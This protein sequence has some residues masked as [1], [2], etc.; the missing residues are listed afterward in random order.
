MA[1]RRPVE[2]F[3]FRPPTT[4]A[5]LERMRGLSEA[6]DGWMNLLPGVPEE[7]V[8]PPSRNI[9]SSL[10]GTAQPPVSMC[11][12][13]PPGGARGASGGRGRDEG[14]TIGILHP[15]GR[16]AAAQ[17]AD[18]GVA[19]PVGWRVSQDH[20][21]RGLIAHPLSGAPLD[22]QLEWMLR[23]GAALAVVPLSGAWQAQVF[24]PRTAPRLS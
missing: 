9:F 8:E 5:V 24:L 3:E 16:R 1:A 10:F 4:T 17:L 12:W 2:Q 20:S 13:I 21:R 22:D 23:A 6:R 15:R 7:E 19:V 11:T 18:L 14:E